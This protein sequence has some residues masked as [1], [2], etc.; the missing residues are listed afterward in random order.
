MRGKRRDETREPADGHDGVATAGRERSGAGEGLRIGAVALFGGC[1]LLVC[2]WLMTQAPAS[3]WNAVGVL[4]PML[5]AIAVGA[6]RSGQRGP[7]VLAGLAVC[8]LCTQALLGVQ[9]PTRWM[10]LAQHAGIHVFLALVFGATLRADNTPLITTLARRV[11]RQFTADMAAYTRHC[12]LAW[13]VYFAGMASVSI[14]LFALA[15]FEAWALFANLLT[16]AS[17]VAMF[18]GEHVLRYRLHPEFERASF[19]DAIR[20][21]RRHAGE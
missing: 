8:A 9:V 11:H 3:P 1:Y 14:A 20:S 10:F 2:H 18:V 17:L 5:A 7:G 21:Y 4:A 15:P 6:W 12:T 19:A 16:P 13:V